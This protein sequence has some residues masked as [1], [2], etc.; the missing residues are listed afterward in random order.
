MFNVVFQEAVTFTAVTSQAKS[1][2]QVTVSC[3]IVAASEVRVVMSPAVASKLVIVA[4]VEVNVSIV[5]VAADNVPLIVTSPAK[6]VSL[7]TVKSSVVNESAVAVHSEEV[8]EVRL[9]IVAS[10]AFTASA[11]TVVAFTTVHVNSH[12]AF[13]LPVNVTSPLIVSNVTLDKSNSILSIKVSRASVSRDI[14]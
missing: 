11:F 6:D 10:S 3:P 9:S 7:L 13:M 4:S 14:L 1:D 12:S 2:V 5:Q 8:V